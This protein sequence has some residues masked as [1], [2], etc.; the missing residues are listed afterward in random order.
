LSWWMSPRKQSVHV[1]QHAGRLLP[2]M[3]V[4]RQPEWF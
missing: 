4:G 2:I 3:R 1:G